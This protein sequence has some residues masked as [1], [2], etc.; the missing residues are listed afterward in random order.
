MK[1]LNKLFANDMIF[2]IIVIITVFLIWSSLKSFP[3]T[4]QIN[5]GLEAEL[6]KVTT[7][8]SEIK[9]L[10]DVVEDPL[11]RSKAARVQ[12]QLSEEGEIIFIFPE[13]Y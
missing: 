1:K 10:L 5:N 2:T 4:I 11:E 13:S 6:K 3:E 8:N 7:Q 9:I 12:Y